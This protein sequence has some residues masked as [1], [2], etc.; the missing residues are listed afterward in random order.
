MFGL[1]WCEVQQQVPC[2]NDRKKSK[3][4]SKFDSKNKNNGNS[5]GLDAKGAKGAKFRKG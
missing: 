1:W 5:N 4:E 2:G 3:S